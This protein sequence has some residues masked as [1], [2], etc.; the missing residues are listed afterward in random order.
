MDDTVRR[1]VLSLGVSLPNIPVPEE[2]APK[3]VTSLFAPIPAPPATSREVERH[4]YL[5]ERN[6]RIH[7]EKK[8]QKLSA[9]ATSAVKT[10]PRRY[11]VIRHLV[12]KLW[13][14]NCRRSHRMIN[15]KQT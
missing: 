9:E 1:L 10:V 13:K 12:I 6:R 5:Q 2:V 7:Q 11:L 14:I 4:A 15:V 8:R 3:I